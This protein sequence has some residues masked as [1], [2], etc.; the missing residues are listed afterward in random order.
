MYSPG[1]FPKGYLCKPYNGGY[2]EVQAL[3][4]RYRFDPEHTPWTEMS[5]EARQAFLFGDPEPMKFIYESRT[6]RTHRRTG[7]FG[8][9]YRWIGDW[10]VGG[11]YTD[12]LVC[13]GCG[14]AKL[15]PEYASVFLSSST[16]VCDGR[17]AVLRR[18][19]NWQDL[20]EMPLYQLYD[21]LRATG[22]HAR[23]GDLTQGDGEGDL[24][25]T[26]WTDVVE[27]SLNTAL[28]RLSFLMQ[29]GLDY[30]HLDRRAGTLSAGE[31]QRIRLAGLLGS[32]LV[33]LTVL[34]DEPTR[35]LHPS[36]V[37]ALV[38]AL[39]A[40]RDEGDTVV[41]VEHDMEVIAAADHLIDMGPGAGDQGGQV[42]AQGTP[43]AVAMQDTVTAR[44]LRGQC[45]RA[46]RRDRR[47]PKEWLTICG[48]RAHNLRNVTVRLPLGVLVGLCGVSGSGKSTLLIDTLGRALA[49]VKQTTSVAYEDVDPGEHDR[50]D[51]APRR[52]ILVDQTKKGVHSPANF[53]RL[54]KP[55]HRLYA[56]SQDARSLGLDAKA[57]AQRCSACRGSGATVLD[58]GFLPN[59]HTECE[60]CRGTG[61][62]PEAWH[63][64][65]QGVSLPALFSMTADQVSELLVGRLEQDAMLVRAL[66]A[67]H[68]V[69]LGYLVL[70]QP[71]YALSGG[72]AQ[73]LK[74][75]KELCRPRVRRGASKGGRATL[76]ILDE[77][78]LGQ[79]LEDVARLCRVLHM[80]VGEGHSVLV[81][82]HHPHL[83]ASC[84]WLVELGPGGGPQGGRVVAEGTPEHVACGD[85]PTAPYLAHLLEEA[86]AV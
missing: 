85:T 54:G 3:A 6:G 47:E 78:T 55:I 25:T 75:A 33:S 16:A 30:V 66:T 53:L 73:R 84:D 70:R 86:E 60:V 56:E 34:L 24:G 8:G 83:L 63:I 4:A 77:P 10:D 15:R 12:T 72:E 39:K 18:E 59:V 13:P 68:E 2:Y 19:C 82:E 41:V 64:R 76:Y 46:S 27:P 49:P 32:G 48:A 79:H 20:N 35:G 57:L 58:M 69:G 42:V 43:E 7:K 67:M 38:D 74:I 65:Y 45:W 80:L 21:L 1:F 9:F 23:R 50:I 51:G 44:W 52:V 28:V 26:H 22:K 17:A 14:G 31:A 61:Y 29:V 81:S 40:L 36:E 37:G 5:E 62:R 11:T 71:G